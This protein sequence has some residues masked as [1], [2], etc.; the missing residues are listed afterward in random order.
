MA[1]RPATERLARARGALGVAADAA[2]L[3]GAAWPSEGAREC[4]ALIARVEE[5]LQAPTTRAPAPPAG[6]A[7]PSLSQESGSNST[8]AARAPRLATHAR[9]PALQGLLG[10][11]HAGSV[12]LEEARLAVGA[13]RRGPAPPRARR[14]APRAARRPTWGACA[15]RAAAGRRA[16][17]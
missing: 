16:G 14:R 4:E 2:R 11:M 9:P 10:K 7:L 17:G 6:P 1:G 12:H 3:H 15:R 8:S 5:T 13:A